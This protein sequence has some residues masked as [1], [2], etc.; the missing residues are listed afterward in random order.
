MHPLLR[1]MKFFQHNVYEQVQVA[2]PNL[3]T[4]GMEHALVPLHSIAAVQKETAFNLP[5][6]H[7]H[8]DAEGE[9][10]WL[11]N[12]AGVGNVRDRWVKGVDGGAVTVAELVRALVKCAD[13]DS[14]TFDTLYA[15]DKVRFELWDKGH[16]SEDGRLTLRHASWSE[17]GFECS[18]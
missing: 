13:P 17:Q 12:Q 3:S 4:P 1:H 9:D 11:V 7:I 5:F 8:F 15:Y 16:V 18:E 2:W 10:S 14:H 6:N